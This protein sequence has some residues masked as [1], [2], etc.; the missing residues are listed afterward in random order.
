MCASA[1]DAVE[2]APAGA[3]FVELGAVVEEALAVDDAAAPRAARVA[4]RRP[5]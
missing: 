1:F 2:G 5:G 3:S 4:A